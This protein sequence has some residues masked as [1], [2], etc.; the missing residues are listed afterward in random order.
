MA[1]K[2]K[3]PDRRGRVQLTR[4]ILDRMIEI[5]VGEDGCPI[6]ISAPAAEE[7]LSTR[8]VRNAISMLAALTAHPQK[9]TQKTRQLN[10][11]FVRSMLE[12]LEFDDDFAEIR[13]KWPVID[14][15]QVWPL[16]R[17]RDLVQVARLARV[18]RAQLVITR[19]GDELRSP[20]RAGEL[21]HTLLMT[22]LTRYNIAATDRY[23][24]D[25]VMGGLLGPALFRFGTLLRKPLPLADFADRLPHDADV[26][27]APL[28][29]LEFGIDPGWQMQAAITRRV[30]EPLAEFGLLASAA[31]EP[32]GDKRTARLREDAVRRWQVTPLFDRVV[33]L[34]ADG[35]TLSLADVEVPLPPGARKLV[36]ESQRMSVRESLDEY[37]RSAAAGD[38][39]TAARLRQH[40]VF[41]ERVSGVPFM[42]ASVGS[43]TPIEAT[44]TRLPAL[45]RT[46]TGKSGLRET[47]AD[48]VRVMAVICAGWVTWCVTHGQA[49]HEV[50][51]KALAELDPMLPEELTSGWS[52]N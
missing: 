43:R 30:L 28:S 31:G 5:P 29:L 10:R 50:G 23:A 26:W 25:H 49:R 44:I 12:A 34:A 8:M 2:K 11:R 17:L 3:A 45:L 4:A 20:D 22:Y 14:E 6:V 13:L 15:D 27:E 24:E 18:H 46:V 19:R 7:A 36:P 39:E 35:C 38:P 51:A 52:M 41:V 1:K 47:R 33:A 16:A 40:L 42:T 37:A 21:H 9:L 32:T 48:E